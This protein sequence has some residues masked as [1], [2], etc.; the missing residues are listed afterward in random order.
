MGTYRAVD[1]FIY[2]TDHNLLEVFEVNGAKCT[3]ILWKLDLEVIPIGISS[4][5][6]TCTSVQQC[7]NLGCVWF[8]ETNRE[9]DI[10]VSFSCSD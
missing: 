2:G 7:F 8:I 9:R 4:N 10:R 5:I 3:Y 1:V 6:Q